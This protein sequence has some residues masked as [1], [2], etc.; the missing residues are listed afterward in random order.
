MYIKFVI[1]VP[2]YRISSVE[3]LPNIGREYGDDIFAPHLA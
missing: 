2:S 3:F 1:G